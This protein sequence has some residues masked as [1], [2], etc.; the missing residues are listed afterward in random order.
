MTNNAALQ[1]ASGPLWK[2]A[3]PAPLSSGAPFEKLI[4]AGYSLV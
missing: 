4:G 1:E 3:R 2:Y